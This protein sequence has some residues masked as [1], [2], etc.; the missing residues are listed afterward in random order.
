MLLVRG[1]LPP[2]MSHSSSYPER[3]RCFACC[4][5]TGATVFIPRG[6]WIG[7]RVEGADTA[8]ILFAF[9][10]PGFEKCLRFL[11]APTGVAFTPPPA[12][13]IAAARRE[14]HQVRRRDE[15]H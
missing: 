4:A 10:I 3:S 14:C 5:H 2:P 11:S 15:V 8:T 9:N 6:T 1:W 7:F 12:Q 13:A